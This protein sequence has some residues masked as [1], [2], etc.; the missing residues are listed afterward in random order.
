MLSI[1]DS[2]PV[3][4]FPITASASHQPRQTSTKQRELTYSPEHELPLCSTQSTC[5][6]PTLLRSKSAAVLTGIKFKIV[7]VFFLTYFLPNIKTSFSC[8]NFSAT[9]SEQKTSFRFLNF[10]NSSLIKVFNLCPHG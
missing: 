1:A 6:K 2:D 9:M 8:F 3:C 4:P 5:E 7:E 10:S